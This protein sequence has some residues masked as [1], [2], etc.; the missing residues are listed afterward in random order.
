MPS[1][2][3]VLAHWRNVF[4][5]SSGLIVKMGPVEPDADRALAQQAATLEIDCIDA[6]ISGGVA[7]VEVGN[8]AIFVDGS[9]AALIRTA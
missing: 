9:E 7:R 4:N 5:W 8:L 6:P 3:R 1:K 2:R